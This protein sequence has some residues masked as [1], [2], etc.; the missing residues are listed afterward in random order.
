MGQ[1]NRSRVDL[2]RTSQRLRWALPD[3]SREEE[4]L[5][6][7]IR[8]AQG[9]MGRGLEQQVERLNGFAL[10][11]RSLDPQRTLSRG[12]TVVQLRDDK[13]AITSVRQVKGRDRWIST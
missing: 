9:V 12:Y 2:E 4:R 8:H 10:Q 5:A 7:L 1:L 3:P 6:A 13:Q 11:L